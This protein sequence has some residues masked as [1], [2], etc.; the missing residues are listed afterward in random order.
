MNYKLNK[1]FEFPFILDF[2]EILQNINEISTV[3]N[4]IDFI[5]DLKS[6]IIHSGEV[7]KGHYYSLIKEMN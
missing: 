7:D 2:R 4:N 1:F 3:S 6:I 5:Y